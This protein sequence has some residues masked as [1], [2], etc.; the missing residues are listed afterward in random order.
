MSKKMGM[1]VAAMLAPIRDGLVAPGSEKGR[2]LL[3]DALERDMEET[4]RLMR[5]IDPAALRE[6][7]RASLI[8][9]KRISELLRGSG[10]KGEGVTDPFGGVSDPEPDSPFPDP[11]DQMRRGPT[12]FGR[13]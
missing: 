3:R 12:P 13:G 4:V 5:P 10:L 11:A 9:E 1:T 8:P 2:N 6:G 7:M